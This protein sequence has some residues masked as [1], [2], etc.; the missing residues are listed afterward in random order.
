MLVRL[1]LESD[2]EALRQMGRSHVA[3]ITPELEWSDVRAN[4][5][6]DRYMTGANP[7]FLVVEHRREVIG[8]LMYVVADF[9]FTAGFYAELEL[10][11]VRP[12]NRGSRAAALLMNEFR[13]WVKRVKP[14]KVL[15][16]AANKGISPKTLRF[17]QKMGFAPVGQVYELTGE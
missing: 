4:A 11:Y 5:T 10:I 17:I 14:A 6:F 13:T 2:R 3:E 7:T 15:I 12:V 1:A 16:S 9:A 8:Y